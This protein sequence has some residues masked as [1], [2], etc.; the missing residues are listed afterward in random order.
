MAHFYKNNPTKIMHF[1]SS[2]SAVVEISE[3]WELGFK[4]SWIHHEIVE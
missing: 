2:S 3:N 4:Q 1:I